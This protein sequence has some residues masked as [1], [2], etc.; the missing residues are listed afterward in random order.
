MCYVCCHCSNPALTTN[1]QWIQEMRV[2]ACSSDLQSNCSLT[3]LYRNHLHPG[4]PCRIPRPTPTPLSFIPLPFE[5]WPIKSKT[6]SCALVAGEAKL[7]L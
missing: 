7:A 3:G 6:K 1:E 2:S 4:Q 5:C